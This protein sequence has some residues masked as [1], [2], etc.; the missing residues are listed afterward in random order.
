MKKLLFLLTMLTFMVACSDDDKNDIPVS[1]VEIPKFENPVAPGQTITIKGEGFT[2]K[3]E[4]WFRQIVTR[5]TDDVKAEVT[6]VDANGITFIAPSVYGKQTILLKQ[7]GRE[8]ELGEMLFADGPADVKI[9]P[10]KIKRVLYYEY[11]YSENA[12]DVYEYE[13]EYDVDGRIISCKLDD[14]IEKYTYSENKITIK[15]D[16]YWEEYNFIVENGRI[17]SYSHIDNEGIEN[18]TL[19]YDGDY[20]SKVNATY[21]DEDGEWTSTETFS[22]LNGNMEKYEYE[23]SDRDFTDFVFT[24]GNQLNNLN[25]DLFYFF[26]YTDSYVTKAFQFDMTGKRSRYL[27]SSMKIL[28]IGGGSNTINL[29]YEMEGEYITK[30]TSKNDNGDI[31]EI[32]EIEYE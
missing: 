31:E 3:S 16:E 29:E 20:L 21:K 4:I 14:E 22:F 8:Y 24:Y 5:A 25:I 26:D 30:I 13:Y 11:A 17:N 10:R 27:P 23:G 2:S 12:D 6:G 32:Y 18:G 1:G 19:T 28:W 15:N 9:L 7:D